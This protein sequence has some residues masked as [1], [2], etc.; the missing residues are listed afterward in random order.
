MCHEGILQIFVVIIIFLFDLR[1]FF[2]S[3][4]KSW[5]TNSLYLRY[6]YFQKFEN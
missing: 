4:P 2:L 5:K 1:L 6:I 3:L